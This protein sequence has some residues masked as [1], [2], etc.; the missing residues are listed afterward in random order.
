MNLKDLKNLKN[1]RFYRND[2]VI[3][4]IGTLLGWLL[5][6]IS[7]NYIENNPELL[8]DLSKDKV[9][10]IVPNVPRGGDFVIGGISLFKAALPFLAEHGFTAGIMSSILGILWGKVP[11]K[12]INTTLRNSVPINRVESSHY[13]I[14]PDNETMSKECLT[15]CNKDLKYLYSVLKNENIL[16]EERDKRAHLIFTKYLDLKTTN[17]RMNFVVCIVFM[18]SILFFSTHSSFYIAM[19]AFIEAIRAGK[20]TKPIARVIVRKLRKRGIPVDPE[21]TD[22]ITD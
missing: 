2:L 16:F 14:P 1:V 21:L 5:Q 7:N 20:I 3:L 9:K 11:V 4:T 13:S 19:K 18:F 6:I 8:D 22:L 10:D 17:G 15:E 12:A